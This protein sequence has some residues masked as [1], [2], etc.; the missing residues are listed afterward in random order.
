[1]K[2]DF[3]SEEYSDVKSEEERE[4]NDEGENIPAKKGGSFSL[5]HDPEIKEREE[6]N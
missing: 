4:T 5:C 1:M 6:V 3:F 2:V